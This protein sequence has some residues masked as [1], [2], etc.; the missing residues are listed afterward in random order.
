MRFAREPAEHRTACG[1]HVIGVDTHRDSHSAAIVDAV[2]GAVAIDRTVSAD[3]FGH[4]R[5][6]RFVKLHATDRQVWAIESSGSFDPAR[7]TRPEAP[8]LL[9]FGAGPRYCIGT[10]LAKVALE[11]CVRTVLA[12]EPPLH[13][14]GAGDAGPSR[15]PVAAR[16]A[17]M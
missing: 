9:L 17:R 13:P 16:P 6:L 5:P 2:T 1:D 15:Q 14:K 12:A 10:A 4:K 11:E 8:K 3:A 7:F